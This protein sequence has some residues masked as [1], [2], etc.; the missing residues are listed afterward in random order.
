MAIHFAGMR[1]IEK[2]RRMRTGG[3]ANFP[4]KWPLRPYRARLSSDTRRFGMATGEAA[5]PELGRQGEGREAYEPPRIMIIGNVRD[6]TTGNSSSG[7][8]DANSQYY[9]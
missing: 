7:T 3:S 9:W 6:L 5:V 1:G 4:G 2:S 8:R